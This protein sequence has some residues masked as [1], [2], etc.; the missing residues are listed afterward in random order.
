[1]LGSDNPSAMVCPSGPREAAIS[2]ASL[3]RAAATRSSVIRPASARAIATTRTSLPA[4]VAL[5]CS[6]RPREDSSSARGSTGNG[7]NRSPDRAA[8]GSNRAWVTRV[9]SCPARARP[10]PRPV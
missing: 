3:V 1:M 7:W 8:S 5:R 6:P 10:C 9:T 4:P 2:S